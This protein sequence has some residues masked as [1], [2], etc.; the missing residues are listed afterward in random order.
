MTEGNR[1]ED[2]LQARIRFL[3]L[4]DPLSRQHRGIA[5]PLVASLGERPTRV[6]VSALVDSR[7][8]TGVAQRAVRSLRPAPS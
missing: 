3:H 8:E 5:Q 6:L 7:Y 2:A 1:E 4:P